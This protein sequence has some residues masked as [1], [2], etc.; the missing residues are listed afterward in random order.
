MNVRKL[1]SYVHKLNE[2]VSRV[3]TKKSIQHLYFEETAAT[4]RDHFGTNVSITASKNKGKIEIDFFSD[5]D[6]ARI[7]QLLKIDEA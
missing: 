5:E 2:D 4:L 1:E 6:L 7:L 3:T